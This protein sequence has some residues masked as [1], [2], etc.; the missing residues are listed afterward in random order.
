MIS[1]KTEKF[2]KEHPRYAALILSNIHGRIVVDNEHME[3]DG[4]TAQE[5]ELESIVGR[6]SR[7]EDENGHIERADVI[8]TVSAEKNSHSKSGNVYEFP[9]KIIKPRTNGQRRYIELLN[10]NELVISIGPAG[11]GKTYLAV[12]KALDSL[13]NRRMRKIILTRPA[14]EAGESLGFLPGD[15][16]EKVDPY[17][18]PLY[19]ALYSMMERDRVERYIAEE[20]IEIAPLAY[21][22]GRTL[23]DSYLILDEAQNTTSKQMKMFITRMG[24]NSRTIITGDITQVDLKRHERSGLIELM[25]LTRNLQDVGIV[26]LTTD[27]VVRHPLVKS[28]INAYL[29]KNDKEDK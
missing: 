29:E 24:M 15:M 13:L 4:N 25:D 22:R 12:A 17:L 19:D 21:M 26:R 14:V 16:K 2:L 1:L 20:I 11:T 10:D 23:S 8:E 7:I 5:K 18:R 3:F 27:D 6:L 28:I 9:K